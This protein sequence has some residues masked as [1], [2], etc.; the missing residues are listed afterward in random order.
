M[1]ESGVNA[2]GMR[3]PRLLAIALG[4]LALASCRSM[5]P[6]LASGAAGIVH[7]GCAEPA[8]PCD[9]A[10]QRG[11]EP[12]E[13]RP[14]PPLAIVPPPP[15]PVAR[16]CKV[17]DGGDSGRPAKPSGDTGIDNLTSGDTVARFRASDDAPAA[18]A[19][20]TDRGAARGRDPEE[21]DCVSVANCACV[22]APRFASVRE[23]VRPLEDY[24][25]TGPI[26]AS[27]DAGP[28]VAAIRLKPRAGTQRL[29]PVLARRAIPE[30]A[31]VEAKPTLGV[32][33]ARLPGETPYVCV[34]AE[35]VQDDVPQT[36]LAK[37]RQKIAVAFDVPL[38]WTCLA[39]AQVM[40]Q[41]TA[42]E[43]VTVDQ[44]TA[45]LRLKCPGRA[46]L[47][48]CK[49]AGGKTVRS[50][51]ELDFTIAFLNS[52]DR[53]LEGIVLADA[54]PKRLAYVPDSADSTLPADFGT[55][56]AADGATVLKW[57]FKQPLSPGES[58]FVRFRTLVR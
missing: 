24:A 8:S 49:T 45:V 14:C 10:C 9:E 38:A 43:T 54:L 12:D 25:P 31:V 22:C 3:W 55:E 23:I 17:C 1:N 27:L 37:E 53:K 47:S 11:C 2:T 42:A 46:E 41:D 50:G 20:D 15:V 34:P 39:Q 5:T 19:G 30:L 56:T 21:C 18:A 4:A 16:V 6:P 57:V 58:G 35:D 48:L 7:S 44:G 40:V 52:G 29:P 28:E 13:C 32:E 26:A 36:F 51:E 33:E